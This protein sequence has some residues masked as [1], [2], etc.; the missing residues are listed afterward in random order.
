MPLSEQ[1]ADYAASRFDARLPLLGERGGQIEAALQALPID[2]AVLTRY[3]YATLPLTDVFDTPFDV[4]AAHAR[5]ALMLRE[6]PAAELPE[7]VFV[8]HVACPRVNN[9]PLDRCREALW[10]TLAPRVKGLTTE[11]AV[12]EINYWC[13]EVATYQTTDNRTLGPLGV[14]AGAAGRCGEEAT[15]LVSALRSVGIPARQIYVP[16]WSHCD[17]NHAWVEAFADGKWH[18]LGACEPE[19]ALDRGWFTAASGRAPM[20]ATRL[21]SDFGCAAEDVLMRSG[22]AVT[23]GVTE[24]YADCSPLEVRVFGADGEPAAGATVALEVLNMAGWR[25]LV[26]LTTNDEGRC[27]AVLGHGSVRVHASRGS[28]MAEKDV[29]TARADEVRL[30]LSAVRVD[31]SNSGW[32]GLDFRAPEDHPAPSGTLTPEM[33]ERGRARK[34][35]ADEKRRASVAAMRTHAKELA[36]RAAELRPAD[37][38]SLVARILDGALGNADEVFSFLTAGT[39]PERAALLAGLAEKDWLDLPADVLEGHLAAALAGRDGALSRLAAEGLGAD[40][41]LEA[42]ERYVLC[43]RI[44]LEHLSAW[45]PALPAALPGELAGL[46]KDDPRAAWVWLVEHLRFTASEHVAKL[47]GTPVGA[48]ESGEASEV[49]RRTLF[50]AACRAL[51]VAARLGEAD[52]RAEVLLAGQWAC[53]EGDGAD[54]DGDGAAGGKAGAGATAEEAEQV[55]PLRVTCGDGRAPVYGTDW[56]LAR[57]GTSMQVGGQELYGF[58]SLDLWGREFE[59]GALALSVP[60]GLYRLTTTVRLPNGNQQACE[61]TL[62]V[63]GPSEVALQLRE[64]DAEDMLQR[65]PLPDAAGLARAATGAGEK[66]LAL[67]A[68]LELAE[69]PTEH[70]LNELADSAAGVAAAGVGVTLVTREDPEAAATGDPTLSRSVGALRAA[71]VNVAL[72]RDDFSELPERLAR[73]MFA[74]PELLPLA[75]LL[76]CRGDAPVG[77]FARGG[78]AVGTV[79]LTLRLAALA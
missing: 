29:D 23:V 56:S 51:G 24:S 30:A 46:V 27:R 57:L 59:D 12:I 9:E 44:G 32:R 19:E 60:A 37:D 36:A 74:N 42:W 7:D 79:E 39:E 71:G 75:L 45:R 41:A 55:F 68:F 20:V 6:G 16:W 70:L 18:Y 78:Y 66:D 25:P 54:G 50:V 17:D 47:V 52:G 64:P 28:F 1:L 58:A 11:Q 26:T 15:L 53:V 72:A 48:L 35:A 31:E 61:R 22:C 67:V 10:K 43:P 14:I 73:R 63:D 13:A 76:D 49:T 3:F 4:L 40:A 34:A 8:H 33:A 77:V 21:F 38:A 65:I 62:V 5:H 2:E 69:E